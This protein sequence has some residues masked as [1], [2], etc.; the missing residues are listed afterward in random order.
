VMTVEFELNGHRFTALNGGPVFTFQ[1]GGQA[2][3]ENDRAETESL[4]E[5]HIRKAWRHGP[6]PSTWIQG[7]SAPDKRLPWPIQGSHDAVQRG[8]QPTRPRG[9]STHAWAEA[10]FRRC[11]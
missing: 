5:R 8:R 10:G 3:V 4:P 6:L 2:A 11:A 7:V 1:L 9:E